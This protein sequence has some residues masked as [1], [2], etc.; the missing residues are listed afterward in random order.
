MAGPLYGSRE[1]FER[2]FDRLQGTLEH[3]KLHKIPP[4]AV[5][6]AHGNGAVLKNVFSSSLETFVL[7]GIITCS[8]ST[9]SGVNALF[10]DINFKV[11]L[12]RSTF[13]IHKIHRFSSKN[14]V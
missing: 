9:F 11:H 6:V 3:V 5:D 12:V 8:T 14:V 1:M 2:I 4:G 10:N 13:V 7:K